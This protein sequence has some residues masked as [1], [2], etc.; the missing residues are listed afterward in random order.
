MKKFVDRVVNFY[1][2]RGLA[3][4]VP[5]L[6]FYLLV[7]LAPL[8]L[9]LAAIAGI[10]FADLLTPAE[11]ASALSERFPSEVQDV[12]INL[13][14]SVRNNLG[15][16]ILSVFVMA[17]TFSS[18]LMVIEHTMSPPASKAG[19]MFLNRI[20]LLFLGLFFAILLLIAIALGTILNGLIP[21]F[22]RFETVIGFVILYLGCGLIYFILPRKRPPIKN[23]LIGAIPSAISLFFAPYLLTL[24]LSIGRISWGGVFAAVA[25]LLTSCYLIAFGLLIGAGIASK[26]DDDLNPNNQL[27]RS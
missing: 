1:W 9:G 18:A 16:V 4:A 26:R 2:G 3:L 25:I 19:E 22:G 21:F 20:R 11:V 15:A 12:I 8:I 7:S 14:D 23:V 6:A 10:V 5:M 17:W 13:A 24:Y 27:K